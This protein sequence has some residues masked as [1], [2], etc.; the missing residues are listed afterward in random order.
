MATC[1][2]C[3]RQIPQGTGVQRTIKTGTYSEGGNYLRNV[4]LCGYCDD[5][6]TTTAH[7]TKKRR[8]LVLLAGAVLVSAAAAGVWYLRS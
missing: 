6:M 1:N 3:G 5:S 8:R 7:S 2:Q 4:N